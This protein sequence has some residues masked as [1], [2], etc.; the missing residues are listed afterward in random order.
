[1]S[2]F[3]KDSENDE[4]GQEKMLNLFEKLDGLYEDAIICENET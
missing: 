2:G 3:D 1:L 4:Q